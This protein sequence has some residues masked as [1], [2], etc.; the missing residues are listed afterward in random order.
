M[1]EIKF[2]SKEQTVCLRGILAIL[3]VIHHLHQYSGL[4][5]G[6][7]IGVILEL[8]GCLSVAVFFFISGY[9]L[10]L[11][12]N[13]KDYLDQ[14]LTKRFLPLYCFYVF[15]IV[16]YSLWTLLLEGSVFPNRVL[17]SF[18]FG[19]TIVK[20]GW[21]LQTTFIAYLLYYFIF[22]IFKSSK[23]RIFY[24][25][26]GVIAYCVVCILL[27]L[28]THWYQ[29]IPC[30]VLGMVYCVNKKC[31]DTKIKKHTWLMFILFS[32]LFSACFI[33]SVLS[34][35]KILF[36]VLFSLFFV[37]TMIVLLYMLSDTALI[38]NRFTKL[39]GR[40]SFEI[41]VG[42]GLFLGLNRMGYIN[43]V[44]IYIPVVILG[45]A[46][47]AVVLKIVYRNILLLFHKNEVSQ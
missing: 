21:Y 30:M 42:H 39:C 23:V 41:Y 19:G 11:S 28:G 44:F 46:V 4:F 35:I 13:K 38:E 15:L 3:V 1:K 22:K 26:L 27:N 25:G 9:G 36:D 16:I 14:F 47:S 34:G 20:N 18:F 12:A 31:I 40:Y 6:T 29:T 7:Y 24:F 17:Q 37:C 43:N 33:L 10:M 2:M 45:T 32:I 8:F 5:I